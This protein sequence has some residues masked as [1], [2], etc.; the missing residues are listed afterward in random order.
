[1]VS[2]G[3]RELVYRL[4]R[5]MEGKQSGEE[6][7]EIKCNDSPRGICTQG[8]RTL[9]AEHSGCRAVA[10]ADGEADRLD[11]TAK[12]LAGFEESDGCRGEPHARVVGGR[13]ACD[14]TS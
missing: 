8:T 4:Q 11:Y 10:V 5:D 1:M 7:Y 6:A 13:E 2:I 14:A 9:F 3:I 12:V